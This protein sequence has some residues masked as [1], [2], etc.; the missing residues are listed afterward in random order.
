M[1]EITA[2]TLRTW[3]YDGAELALIDVREPGQ[4]IE[5]HILFSAP[6]PYSRFEAGLPRLVPNHAARMVLCDAG[7]GV[8][9]KATAAAEIMGYGSVH[10][11]AGGVQSWEAAGHTL[12]EGVNVPSKAFGEL[13]EHVDDTPRLAASEIARRQQDDA[14]M[15]IVDGRPLEEFRR[16]SIPGASCCPNG[17]LA[18]RA[19]EFAPDPETTVIVNCAGRTRSIIGAQTLID[20][21]IPNPV[22][23]ME[24]GTQ[25]W[26][27]SGMV[28]DEGKD[29]G[30]PGVPGDVEQR[31]A[32]AAALAER[33]GVERVDAATLSGWLMDAERTV[34]L[35][36]VRTAEERAGDPADRAGL[37][38]LHGVMHGPGGQLVQATDQW[39]GVR[40]AAIMVLDTEDLRA[41]VTASWLRRLGHKAFTLEGGLD[42]LGGVAS[43]VVP[44]AF[45]LNAL[46]PI[47]A[48][49][50]EQRMRADDVLLLDLR[51]SISYRAGHIAGA[52]WSIRPR[53]PAVSAGQ[54]VVLAAKTEEIALLAAQD[55]KRGGAG[56]ILLLEGNADTW[57][58][59]GLNMVSSEDDPPDDERID[60][61][62]FTAGRHDG[63]EAASRRYLEWEIALVDQLD[64]QERAVF[65]I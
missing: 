48:T 65:R 30:L 42:A 5:A 31:K 17:E 12:Y 29:T 15:V 4:C 59:A 50:L 2:A 24:N 40:N 62:T 54:T 28:L 63:D 13:V 52:R 35:L 11:L 39:I 9:A 53:L 27:L 46:P 1:N 33:H 55:L 64:D 19:S 57:R 51:S 6:L 43:Q 60:F 8:A 56:E 23:A 38:A 25:G 14:N 22:Y 20:V 61:L 26:V 47:A 36:D 41:P 37:M 34:Y 44:T 7:D 49:A 32:N 18:L 16:F 21:G 10:V 58:A 45:S 3:L